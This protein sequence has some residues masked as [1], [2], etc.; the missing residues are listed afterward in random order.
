[1]YNLGLDIGGTKCA[2]LLG[3]ADLRAGKDKAILQKRVFPTDAGPARTMETVYG[4]VDDMLAA[5]GIRPEDI[6]GIGISCGGPLDSE[7][8]RILGP[9]NLYGWDDVPIVDMLQ[10][11][12]GVKARL[13]ND[14]NACAVAEWKFGAAVGCD[15]VVFL[16]FGTGLGAGMVLNGRLYRGASGMAG[17]VGHVRLSGWGPVGYGKA[18]SF[19][20]FCSGGGIAQLARQM[21]LERIQQGERPAFC[22]TLAE[23]PELTAKTVADAADG[24]D[25][26]AKEIYALS[27]Q[28]LGKGLA[29]LVDILNPQVIVLGSIFYRSEHLLRPAMQRVL[30]RESLALSRNAC[31]VVSS[32]LGDHIGDYAALSVALL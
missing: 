25:S 23:L 4:M 20:G 28:Y 7:S 32:G 29:M 2:V 12:Y 21:V 22:P 15:S 30:E 6:A 9:P 3:S 24:G 26:L 14:A 31:R 1:M 17:E 8:G 10:K 13:E 18:G 5:K 27:G 19:E 16:T 11:K